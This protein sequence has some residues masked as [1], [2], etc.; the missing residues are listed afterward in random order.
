MRLDNATGAIIE[1]SS[2]TE[3]FREEKL[4]FFIKISICGTS[5]D[6]ISHGIRPEICS[7]RIWISSFGFLRI[8]WAKNC[9][10]SSNS[11]FLNELHTSDNITLHISVQIREEWLAHMLFIESIGLLR[12]GEFAHLQFWNRETVFVNSINDFAGL[13][14]TVWFNHGEGSS[15][16][17]FKL[18]LC[19]NISV[20]N[21]FKLSRMNSNYRSKVELLSCNISNR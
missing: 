8:S 17:G 1:S 7:K 14:V 21:N 10:E 5:M 19:G 13:S 2:W 9:S 6:S 20:I 16:K 12:F 11:I 15:S 4:W 3:G 18:I